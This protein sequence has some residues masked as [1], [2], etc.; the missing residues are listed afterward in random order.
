M[1]VTEIR[2]RSA[3][4]GLPLP[5][6]MRKA[7]MIRAIQRGEGNPACFGAENRFSCPELNCCWRSDCLIESP[8]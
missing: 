4:I 8:G 3:A 6:K 5:A 1:R 2:E 7:E